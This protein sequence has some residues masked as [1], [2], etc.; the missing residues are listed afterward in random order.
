MGFAVPL[1][2][3]PA[4]GGATKYAGEIVC[5]LLEDIWISDELGLFRPAV[6]SEKN[7]IHKIL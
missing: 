2:T 1:D 4:T 5:S 7:N 3:D 6:P